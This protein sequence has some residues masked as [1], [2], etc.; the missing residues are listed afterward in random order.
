[1]PP[2]WKRECGAKYAY[3]Y[4]TNAETARYL[5]QGP[6]LAREL[7]NSFRWLGGYPGLPPPDFIPRFTGGE[8]P[9]DQALEMLGLREEFVTTKDQHGPR[10][11]GLYVA[12]RPH[13][14]AV[15]SKLGDADIIFGIETSAVLPKADG[16]DEDLLL[17]V[18]A[19]HAGGESSKNAPDHFGGA[20]LLEAP[21][22]R[23]LLVRGSDDLS[24]ALQRKYW[25][26]DV[27]LTVLLIIL[28]MYGFFGMDPAIWRVSWRVEGSDDRGA[29][30]RGTG[31]V[32][33]TISVS[34]TELASLF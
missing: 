29:G 31:G 20:F 2:S 16:V 15:L 23:W 33:P 1:M 28:L 13:Q 27:A 21:P 9:A 8:K 26:E 17:Q 5:I 7:R 12:Q 24:A 4:A 25:R 32:D 19:Y 6:W 18:G 3:F 10:V 11:K 34:E 14:A 22:R 30:E